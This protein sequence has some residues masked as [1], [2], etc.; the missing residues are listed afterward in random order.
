MRIDVHDFM[1]QFCLAK[2]NISCRSMTSSLEE[3][4][5]IVTLQYIFTLL[6]YASYFT[7]TFI[8]LLFDY[9]F[10]YDIYMYFNLIFSL[11]QTV[12]IVH[13]VYST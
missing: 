2:L 4:C 13:C 5:I 6:I 10:T 12:R 7:H 1:A 8:V 3:L 9:L 11:I